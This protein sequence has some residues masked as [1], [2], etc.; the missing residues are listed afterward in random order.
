MWRERILNTL[1]KHFTLF[2]HFFSVTSMR[3]L[4]ST[5]Q[6][7]LVFQKY[8][9]KMILY[10]FRRVITI[11]DKID[12][13][14]LEALKKWNAFWEQCIDINQVCREYQWA[15]ISVRVLACQRLS[16]P[17]SRCIIY[18]FQWL[19]SADE[20]IYNLLLPWTVPKYRNLS[21]VT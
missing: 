12:V 3:R 19:F 11:F 14:P 8:P 2:K 13:G 17:N 6:V 21:Q 10:D 15:D 18:Y 7:F 5:S 9:T 20:T 1:V 4:K 16:K